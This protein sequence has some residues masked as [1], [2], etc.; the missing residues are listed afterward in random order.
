VRW[1]DW[2][3]WTVAPPGLDAV[4]G[5]LI[6]FESDAWT[7]RLG[8][9][10]QLTDVLSAA[11]EVAH[12]TPVDTMMS[13]LSP[14]DGFTS[15]SVGSSYALPSGLTLTG[16]VDLSFLGDAEVATPLDPTPSRFEDSRAVSAQL[17]VGWSF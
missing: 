12:E 7:Y 17:R 2:D 16:A 6:T 15:V 11:V 9:G 8:V 3:G 14:Y 1:V 4:A 5:P 10:R 13:P